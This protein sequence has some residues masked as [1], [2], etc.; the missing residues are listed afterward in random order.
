[1]TEQEKIALS[2][3]VAEL[4]G[5]DYGRLIDSSD[6][7]YT[8]LADDSARC[9]ELAVEHEIC[10]DF[11]SRK[12]FAYFETIPWYD[13]EEWYESHPTKAEATR[14]AILK[15]LVKMKLTNILD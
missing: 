9:F 7:G 11:S 15:C 12:A 13:S 6:Y 3:Q 2:K 8:T 1:M 5:V 14:I 4:Y 10:I